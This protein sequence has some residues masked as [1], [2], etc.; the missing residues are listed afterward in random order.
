LI[1]TIAIF[2]GLFVMIPAVLSDIIMY[3]ISTK[4]LN[5]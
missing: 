5:H 1:L 4:Y 2:G 3:F